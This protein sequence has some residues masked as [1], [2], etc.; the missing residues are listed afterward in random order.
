MHSENMANFK[1]MAYTSYLDI[2]NKFVIQYYY[3]LHTF[4]TFKRQLT[5]K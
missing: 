5:V 3:I 2:D 1:V 4:N